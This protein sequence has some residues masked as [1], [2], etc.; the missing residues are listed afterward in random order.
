MSD[1]NHPADEHRH[2]AD[3]DAADSTGR[4]DRGLDRRD[5]LKLTGA[6]TATAA[7]LSLGATNASA[8]TT[9]HG[10]TFNTVKNAVNDLG[11]DRNGN[12]AIDSKLRNNMQDGTLIEFPPGTYKV[13]DTCYRPGLHNWGICGLG[14]SRGDVRFVG[15]AGKSFKM[16]IVSGA[17][18]RAN[19]TNIL[20]ENVTFDQSTHRNTCISNQFYIQDGLEIHD[21]EIYGYNPN[22]NENPDNLSGLYI[23]I[24]NSGGTGVIE[25]YKDVRETTVADYPKN[26]SGISVYRD[27]AGTLYVRGCN[28]ENKGEHAIYASKGNNVR[29]EGGT[30]KNCANTNMRISGQGSYI[31][32]ADIGIDRERSYFVEND[33]GDEKSGRG[34]W[35]EAGD[36]GK[37]GGYVENCDFFLD[38][39]LNSPG[40]IRVEGTTGAM[41]VRNTRIQN[42]SNEST[43]TVFVQEIGQGPGNATPPTPHD[44]EITDCSFTGSS[45][46][47]AV[48]SNRSAS[49]SVSDC[50]EDMPNG[51][52]FQGDLTTSNISHSNCPVPDKDPDPPGDLRGPK[53]DITFSGGNADK[54]D[55]Y[56]RANGPVEAHSGIG[57][58]DEVSSDSAD[59][60]TTGTGSDTYRFE[61]DV[62]G[63]SLSLG[64]YITASLDRSERTI[65]FEGAHDGTNHGYYLEVTGDLYPTGNSDGHEVQVDPNGDSVSGAVGSGVDKWEYTG[66]LSRIGLN[67]GTA[68]VDVT[69]RHL[70]K[71]EDYDDGTT[72]NYDFTVSGSVKKRGKA[73]SGD[74]VS[75][76][77]VSGY[78][79]G[80]GADNYEY[81]GRIT[82][83]NHSGAVHTY[84][85]R[86]EVITPSLGHNTVT[87]EGD[88]TSRSYK[89]A[90]IGG[91]GKSAINGSI[92]SGDTI[93][94]R[95]AT[96]TVSGGND[97]Y[98]Y[99]DAI[100]VSPRDWGG[101]NHYFETN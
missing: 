19:C 28:I 79:T 6:T 21:V 78:V 63:M 97:S 20:V 90:A 24:L 52:G 48:E 9:R 91:L 37:T 35:W 13:N 71:I 31:K 88:G 4:T 87:I 42:N 46:S 3:L 72:A 29:V 25:N 57:G 61:Q 99:R 7:G 73:D 40:L 85:D 27:H 18:S 89:I 26:C 15:P 98:D 41:E 84:L 49:V 82:D 76:N 23:L 86:K 8:A 81:T 47:P 33:T 60:A 11:M 101:A 54:F 100:R 77:S 94:D 68:T 59:G 80:G 67:G 14:N 62:V 45:P 39:N 65:E 22:E 92:Q 95:I 64:N 34:L 51:S 69:R 16:I 50:C 75:G 32:N 53:N 93:S 56:F 10:I 44:V 17:G 5:Y 66:E 70:L 2:E 58:E 96:G 1:D 30:F 38:T 12:N 55:Y 36:V 74:S 83:W 43:N